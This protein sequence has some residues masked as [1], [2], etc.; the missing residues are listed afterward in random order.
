LGLVGVGC[1]EWSQSESPWVKGRQ[2]FGRIAI[3]NSDA[4]GVSLTQAAIDQANCAIKELLYE[5]V[6]PTFYFGNP[7]R[8]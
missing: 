1:T 8:G 3:A 6:Q 2:R 4:A 5:V 7:A